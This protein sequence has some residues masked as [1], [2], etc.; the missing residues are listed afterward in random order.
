MRRG[1][2]WL[3]VVALA[4]ALTVCA[5][6]PASWLGTMVERQTGGRLTLGDAQGTLWSGSAFVGGAPGLGGSVTPLLPGRFTWRLSPLV[7]VG[8]VD[9]ALENPL[10]LAGPV[11]VTGSWSQWQVSEGQLLLPAEGLAGLGAPLNTLVPSGVIRLSW[12]RLDLARLPNS[13]AVTGRTTLSMSDMGSRMAPVKPLGS[14]EMMMDWRG[15]QADLVL[16]TVRGA[17]LLS[18]NGTLQNGRL[19]FSGQASAADGYEE[20]LGNMLNLLG[21]RRMVNGKNIIALEFR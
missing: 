21:Q 5:F 2:G 20:T 13:V 8:R 17:L 9:M 16:R 3:V 14:Y 1:I 10:A 4:I 6:L 19:R 12:N 18:G 11:Q 15:Q 7:L